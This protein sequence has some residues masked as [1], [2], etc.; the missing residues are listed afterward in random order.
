[1]TKAKQKYDWLQIASMIAAIH[2]FSGHAK[3]N[4]TAETFMPKHLLDTPTAKGHLLTD[5]N[6]DTFTDLFVGDTPCNLP[7]V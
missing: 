1:M 3:R 7:G 6:M 2:N 5:S 4:L